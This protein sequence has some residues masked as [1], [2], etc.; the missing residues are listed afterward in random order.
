[1]FL[2]TDGS[3]LNNSDTAAGTGWYGYWGAG[4]QE[5]ARGHLCLPKHDVFDVEATAALEGL[6]I[7]LKFEQRPG[8]F[9]TASIRPP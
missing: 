7:A 5:F 4:K 3:R 1:M 6:K 8:P 2:F 9:H